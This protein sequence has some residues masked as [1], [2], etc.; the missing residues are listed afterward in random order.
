MLRVSLVGNLAADPEVRSS[1][2][3]APITTWR[4]AV[5][6]IRNGPDGKRQE[7]TEWFRVR[8]M[9]R[10][11][12]YTQRLMKGARVLVIGRLDITHYQSH[13]GEQRVGY[14]VWADEVQNLS[15]RIGLQANA[16]VIREFSSEENVLGSEE[17]SPDLP[18]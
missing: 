13:D 10:L 5:D 16:D 2:Q 4:V 17:E 7:S 15:P 14:D 6:Q 3:G 8:S 12:E 9:G 1:R 18:F 11:A